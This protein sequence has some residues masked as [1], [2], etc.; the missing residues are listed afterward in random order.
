MIDPVNRECCV[1][2]DSINLKDR[3]VRLPCAHIFHPTCVHQWLGKHCTCPVCR[4]ELPTDCPEYERDRQERMRHRKPRFARHE[5]ERLSI[6]EL[7]RLLETLQRQQLQN[8][9]NRKQQTYRP[10]DKHDLIDYLIQSGTIDLVAAPA[11]VEYSLSQVKGMSI[12]ELKRV[13]NEE[14]GVFFDP[15]DVVEKDDLLRIFLLSG[16]LSIIAEDEPDEDER[17]TNSGSDD[18]AAQQSDSSTNDRKRPADVVVDDTTE[19]NDNDND[20]SRRPS[21]GPVT[22]ETVP[23][24]EDG[25]NIDVTAQPSVNHTVTQ[26]FD[27]PT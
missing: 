24:G 23:E 13:M 22:V 10:V 4:Y 19:S 12:R 8:G 16:R 14:A 5:L 25:N 15:K 11:P 17:D 3:V 27:D 18:D 26:M 1:C 21:S 9:S 7:K 6:R 2:L 20:N